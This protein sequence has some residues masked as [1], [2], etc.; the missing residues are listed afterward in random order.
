[1]RG[2]GNQI[3]GETSGK[4]RLERFCILAVTQVTAAE[5]TAGHRFR[6]IYL[7]EPMPRGKYERSNRL[8]PPWLDLAMGAWRL[9]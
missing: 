7:R 6:K 2:F 4:T 5:A 1:M 3:H 9:T 8:H